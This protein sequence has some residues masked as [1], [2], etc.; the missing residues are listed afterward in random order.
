MLS[1]ILP[2]IERRPAFKKLFL[3]CAFRGQATFG[4]PEMYEYLEA[5]KASATRSGCR[6]AEVSN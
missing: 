1:R 2:I 4:N 6:R 5:E 3:S